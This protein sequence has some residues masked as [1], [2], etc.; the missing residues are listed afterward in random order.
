MTAEQLKEIFEK[1]FHLDKWIQILRE[2]L[3][4]EVINTPPIEIDIKENPFDAKAFELGEL[5]TKDGQLIGIYKV[6]VPKVKQLHRNKVGLRDLLKNV[7]KND[8]D[9]A[10]VV[11]VQEKK[12]R[13]SYVSEVTIRDKETGERQDKKTDSKRYTYLLG[14]GEKAKTAAD[15]FAN[16]KQSNDLFGGR[17]NIN[18]FR[19]SL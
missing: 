2:N 13:F 7:Y 1:E 9:A 18:S 4:V 5:E 3:N 14:D 16:I 15:R 6:D 10:L 8:V 17:N 11:F 12:W 19:R